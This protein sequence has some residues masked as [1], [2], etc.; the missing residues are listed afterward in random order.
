MWIIGD[1]GGSGRGHQG[2][3]KSREGCDGEVEDSGDIVVLGI[4]LVGLNNYYED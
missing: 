3:R 1:N 2:G 4:M